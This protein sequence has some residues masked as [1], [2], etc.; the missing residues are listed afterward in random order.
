MLKL[1]NMDVVITGFGD[2]VSVKIDIKLVA[3]A[4]EGLFELEFDGLKNS[5]KIG[6]EVT[7]NYLAV[8]FLGQREGETL[9]ESEEGIFSFEFK[10]ALELVA[11]NGVLQGEDAGFN[12]N[13]GLA[14]IEGLK[15]RS[16]IRTISVSLTFLKRSLG[17]LATSAKATTMF[18]S[19]QS[20]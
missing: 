1:K 18:S 11:G 4:V 20:E 15:I 8:V 17:A 16:R 19:V 13:I 2:D 14:S 10:L 12:V 5:L 9:A 3:V 6:K 7:I